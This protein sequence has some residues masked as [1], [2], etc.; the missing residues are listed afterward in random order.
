MLQPLL[1][2]NQG[3]CVGY[4]L[5]FSPNTLYFHI[6][7]QTAST[8]YYGSLGT[9]KKTNTMTLH[10]MSSVDDIGITMSLDGTYSAQDQ[11]TLGAAASDPGTCQSYVPSF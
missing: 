6:Y 2:N 10:D 3:F 7:L 4:R 5:Y 11:P 9:P 1:I 8:M